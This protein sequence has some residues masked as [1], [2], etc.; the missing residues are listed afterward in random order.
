MRLPQRSTHPAVR[1]AVPPHPCDRHPAK[2]S[3]RHLSTTARAVRIFNSS[4]IVARGRTPRY[5][6]SGRSTVGRSFC[7]ERHGTCD[8][9][10]AT[11]TV[12][13]A[14]RQSVDSTRRVL[15]PHQSVG[16]SGH[17]ERTCVRVAYGG[18]IRSSGVGSHPSHGH[19]GRSVVGRPS[20]PVVPSS[21]PRAAAT[22]DGCVS[23]GT[24]L[25]A[26]TLTTRPE[27]LDRMSALADRR[28]RATLPRH[29]TS[30]R[31]ASR[32][33]PSAGMSGG[34]RRRTHPVPRTR[35]RGTS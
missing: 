16:R 29:A 5:R 4:M 13:P 8:L 33:A 34:W 26:A 15:N 24:G 7:D 25:P 19:L 27:R 28:T 14:A 23:R 18:A 31:A 11:E 2:N 22:R 10:L 6:D 12:E 1:A 21:L 35:L 9:S 17:R 32:P 20:L 3:R 30:N